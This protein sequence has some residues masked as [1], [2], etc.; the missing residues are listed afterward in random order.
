MHGHSAGGHNLWPHLP[1]IEIALH[2]LINNYLLSQSMS[3]RY[4]EIYLTF[5]GIVGNCPPDSLALD[6]F[7]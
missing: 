5:V 1:G 2:T 6:A 7:C 3:A 4:F